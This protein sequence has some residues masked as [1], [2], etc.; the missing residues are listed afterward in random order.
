MLLMNIALT[1]AQLV[2]LDRPR[3]LPV[4]CPGCGAAKE[5]P[6]L[7]RPRLCRYCEMARPKLE[8]K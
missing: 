2:E 4:A 7:N 1:F 6:R 5:A 3:G 8:T